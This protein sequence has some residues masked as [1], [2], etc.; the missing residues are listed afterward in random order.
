MR[1]TVTLVKNNII[2]VILKHEINGLI[3]KAKLNQL[4]NLKDI[5]KKPLRVPSI[6]KHVVT[7]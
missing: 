3:K 6:P 7:N 4:L 5:S 1:E 2:I